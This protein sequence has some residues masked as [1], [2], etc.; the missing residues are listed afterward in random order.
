[1][2]SLKQKDV[3]LVFTYAPA[4]LGHLRVMNALIDGLPKDIDYEVLGA[5]D[6]RITYWHRIMSINPFVREAIESIQSGR[7]RFLFYNF[8]IWLLRHNTESLYAQ[9]KNIILSQ[10]HEKKTVIVVSTHFGLAHQI[11]A[12]KKRLE[13]DL[14]IK[15]LLIDQITDATSMEILYI[16]GADLIFVPDDQIKTNLLK[17][18]RT[19]GLRET[20]IIV[21]PYPLSPNLSLQLSEKEFNLRLKQ[22]DYYSHSQIKIA[23]P[24]SGAAVGLSYYEKIISSLLKKLNRCRI[25]V[26]VKDYVYTWTFIKKMR[27]H[28][29]VRVIEDKTDRKVVI[30]YDKLYHD[31]IIGLEI[32]KPSE[33][34]FK[35]MF[36]SKKRGGPILLL[37]EPIGK[38]EH[39]N[40]DFLLEHHLL[41]D[42]VIQKKLIAHALSNEVPS[43][44]ECSSCLKLARNWKAIR[45]T[46]DPDKDTQ[47]ITWCL[48]VGIFSIMAAN[49]TLAKAADKELSPSGVKLFWQKVETII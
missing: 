4:G 13:K 35:T 1:M 5:S 27:R 18:A 33:Q 36:G 26:V 28:K 6:T 16:P 11:A 7:F 44:V 40:I 32:V 20:N 19:R 39:D 42:D 12:L 2:D 49:T 24:I 41:P 38:Q 37:T 9:L 31:E 17:Y 21:S 15:I 3:L 34:S 29:N 22:Y 8:Y 45:L 14:H 46:N 48:K 10:R 47:I 25:F 23:V 43:Q 30:D